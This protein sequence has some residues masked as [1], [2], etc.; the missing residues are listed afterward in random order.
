ML[1]GWA[2]FIYSITAVGYIL[3]CRVDHLRPVERI[4]ASIVIGASAGPFLLFLLN[5]LFGIPV[6]ASTPTGQA[7]TWLTMAGL[8]G[9][10]IICERQRRRRPRTQRPLTSQRLLPGKWHAT[11]VVLLLIAIAT[12]Y[13]QVI[14]GLRFPVFGW[15]EYSF[16]L[17]TAQALYLHQGHSTV[18]IRDAYATY[19]LG[20]PYLVAWCYH[21]TGGISILRAKWTLPILTSGLCL[22]TY[23]LLRRIGLQ[24]APA[25]AAVAVLLWGTQI[26]LWYNFVAFGEL[27]YVVTYCLGVLYVVAWMAQG[28]DADLWIGGLLLGLSAFLRV[29]GD[30]I[31]VFTL[32]CLVLTANPRQLRQ[33]GASRVTRF[34]TVL[35]IPI[36]AW[37]AFEIWFHAR[38]GWTPRLSL[39]HILDRLRPDFLLPMLHA[40][41]LTLSNLEVY[42]VMLLLAIL[43][44]ML[45]FARNRLVTFLT[46]VSVTH[47]VYL[48]VAYLAVFSSFE[49]LH[50]SAMNR[51]LLRLDPMIAVAFILMTTGHR[52]TKSDASIR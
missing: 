23:A 19:P 10:L 20:F 41:W 35:L 34:L 18:E 1:I 16:W 48:F 27:S 45:P 14:Y 47:I 11:V 43:I 50:A 33:L 17:Y 31:D 36:V 7:F 5:T 44:V 26:Y 42:P 38:A 25:L 40:E 39:A 46:F 15:D 8:T 29:D 37:K 13:Y 30:Y 4:G 51:Y 32:V 28:C 52:G 2:L 9:L 49:A 22:A 21:L 12:F 6:I 24:I 3:L